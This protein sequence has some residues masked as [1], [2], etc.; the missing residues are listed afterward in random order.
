MMNVEKMKM[1]KSAVAKEG[2]FFDY[3]TETLFMSAAWEKKSNTIGTDACEIRDQIERMF[4]TVKTEKIERS[5]KSN[6]VP[7]DMMRA[8]IRMMPDAEANEAELNNV[9]ATSKVFA[10]SYK[11]VAKWFEAKFP[12]YGK[13][14]VKGKDGEQGWN[15]VEMAKLAKKQRENA[16]HKNEAVAD[17]GSN[18][19]AIAG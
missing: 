1:V 16:A 10:S 6:A 5:H 18:I 9:I 17:A 14:V 19:V 12:Y 7:Y 4:P 3:E 2:Y 8:F 11:H 15:A 13:L